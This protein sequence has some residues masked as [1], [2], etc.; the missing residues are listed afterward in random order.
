[1]AKNEVFQYS[2]VSALMDG[3]ATHGTP[4]SRILDHGDHGLGTF[5]SMNGEMIV[6]D[7]VCYQMKS[8][9]TIEHIHTPSEVITPFATVT[10][11]NPNVSTRATI[12]NKKDLPA[13]LLKLYPQSKNHFLA[14]RMDGTF[15]RIKV[16]TA[17]GQCFA[18]E[19]M[20]AV[21]GR[22]TTNT[23]EAVKGTIIGFRCPAYVMGLNVAGDHLHFID[24][25]RQKGGHILEFE[26]EG[27][28]EVGVSLMS[29]FHLEVPTEDEEFNEAS[30]VHDKDGIE[31]VEG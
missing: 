16:R 20:L 5:K 21:A 1:M 15:K 13:L 29:K 18:R 2:L 14:I 9:G 11:F 31:K 19:G 12:S 7:G 28:V 24:E 4:I 26:T 3:V 6:L 23:F 17:G 25:E 8:D 22:Q 27:D 30:L 10:R